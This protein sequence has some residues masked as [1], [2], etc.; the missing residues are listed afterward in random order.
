[1][2]H[3]VLAPSG[4][5]KTE[6]AE[7]YPDAVVNVASDAYERQVE[8]DDESG[9]PRLGERDPLWPSNY[10]GALVEAGRSGTWQY[11]LGAA[12][13]EVAREL[14]QCG[15]P[16]LW[17]DAPGCAME[18]GLAP[19]VRYELAPEQHLGELLPV[20][21]GAL[22]VSLS[23][24]AYRRGDAPETDAL[25]D[26]FHAKPE[27]GLVVMLS[28]VMGS[29]PGSC[30]VRGIGLANVDAWEDAAESARDIR[31]AWRQMVEA[32][33]GESEEGDADEQ[34]VGD[35]PEAALPSEGSEEEAL[36]V[37]VGPELDLGDIMGRIIRSLS[38]GHQNLAIVMQDWDEVEE[39]LRTRA[40]E[41]FFQDFM[42]LAEE[43]EDSMSESL[44]QLVQ[45]VGELS[46]ATV[47]LSL[48]W[49]DDPALDPLLAHFS[50]PEDEGAHLL[51]QAELFGDAWVLN[52]ATVR[53]FTRD[54]EQPWGAWEGAERMA[55]EDALEAKL[56]KVIPQLERQPFRSSYDG[57]ALTDGRK[58]E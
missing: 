12:R 26:L 3:I 35:E 9:E 50:V 30:D 14:E 49:G 6:M 36:A 33:G 20:V 13:L 1:M 11:V 4:V 32:F 24:L 5:G 44:D 38:G 29:M 23:R 58:A 54:Q 8:F 27:Q 18:D 42:N 56:R 41:R 53:V 52:P 15:V 48:L 17:V 45:P 43:Q 21:A 7:R 16:Y 2:A 51:A 40:T 19:S 31:E 28:V 22:S 57:A 47:G 55:V 10:V 46:E 25:L 37:P 34:P 39:P